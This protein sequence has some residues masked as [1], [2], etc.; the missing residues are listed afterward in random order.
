MYNILNT[1][2]TTLLPIEPIEWEQQHEWPYTEIGKRITTDHV[3]DVG[4][5]CGLLGIFLVYYNYCKTVTLYEVDDCRLLYA[6]DLVNLLNLNDKITIHDAMYTGNEQLAN[7]T[8]S[9]TRFGSLNE[10][11]NLIGSNKA[12]TLRRTAEVEPLFNRFSTRVWKGEIIQRSD[13][14]ELEVLTR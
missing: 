4:S 9:S 1:I 5:G 2:Q 13:G 6:R 8:I 11:E 7:T 10:F 14:F 3:L 12:I